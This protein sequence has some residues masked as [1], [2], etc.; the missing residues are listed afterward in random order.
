M[1]KSTNLVSRQIGEKEAGGEGRKNPE[2]NCG[3]SVFPRTP[4]SPWGSSATAAASPPGLSVLSHSLQA[5][6]LGHPL[7]AG[8]RTQHDTG[9]L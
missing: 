8:G 9:T 1:L 6:L 2:Q 4:H 7:Q 5:R 3:G